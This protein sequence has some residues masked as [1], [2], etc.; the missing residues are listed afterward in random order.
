MTSHAGCLAGEKSLLLS[1]LLC[2]D[3]LR[4][5]EEAA[6]GCVR[7]VQTGDAM[8]AFHPT[9]MCASACMSAC[10]FTARWCICQEKFCHLCV[11][12]YE[13][14]LGIRNS[15]ADSVRSAGNPQGRK[16][17]EEKINKSSCDGN[18]FRQS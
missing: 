9:C 2:A 15:P 10:T 16:E 13:V 4:E 18:I 6:A 14:D 1:P 3:Q 17:G 11:F 5:A 8:F 12:V 7:C